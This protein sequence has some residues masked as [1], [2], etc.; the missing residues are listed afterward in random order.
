MNLFYAGAGFACLCVVCVDVGERVSTSTPGVDDCACAH[1][2]RGWD[3][4]AWRPPMYHACMRPHTYGEE[5]PNVSAVEKQTDLLPP[6]ST[7]PLSTISLPDSAEKDPKQ[8]A[9]AAADFWARIAQ[10]GVDFPLC[11]LAP[12]SPHP[13]AT[14]KTHRPNPTKT[15]DKP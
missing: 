10:R 12:Q 6:P 4:A 3:G 8:S 9:T 2:L 7:P 1:T 13:L 14:T 15:K 5:T 11:I